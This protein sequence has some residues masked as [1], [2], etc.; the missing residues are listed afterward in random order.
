MD[1]NSDSEHNNMNGI[2]SAFC[3]FILQYSKLN[4]PYLE[5]VPSLLFLTTE[6]LL[7]VG[8]E[9]PPPHGIVEELHEA[10]APAFYS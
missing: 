2:T 8:H 3:F 9:L 4:A 1:H 5:S 7:Q 10:E 6:F